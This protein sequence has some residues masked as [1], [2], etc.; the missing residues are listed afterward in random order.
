MCTKSCVEAVHTSQRE[1]ARHS[2]THRHNRCRSGTEVTCHSGKHTAVQRLRIA[3]LHN[4]AVHIATVQR[5]R[6]YTLQRYTVQ[7][8]LTAY[9]AA[10]HIRSEHMTEAAV[11]TERQQY[12]PSGSSAN[13]AAAV[14][15]QRQQYQ[16]NGSSTNPTAASRAWRPGRR[17]A[18]SHMAAREA[19]CHKSHGGQ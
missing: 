6:G 12:Q 1:G 16:P 8:S 10:V 11:P 17:T 4:V 14:P 3:A 15:T 5:Y 19:H 7:H 9:V 13:R 2:G 18:T